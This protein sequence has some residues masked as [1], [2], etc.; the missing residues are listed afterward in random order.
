MSI[1]NG[2]LAKLEHTGDYIALRTYSRAHGCKG[3]FLINPSRFA[4]WLNDDG[5]PGRS[6]YLERDI[7]HFLSATKRKWSIRLKILWRYGS[8][9]CRT[10][11]DEQHFDLPVDMMIRALQ[12]ESIRHLHVEQPN[13]ARLDFTNACGVIKRIRE[14][15]RKRRALTKGLRTSF[16]WRGS[17]IS[18]YDD[19]TPC[20]FYFQERGG[21]CG[22]LILH[23]RETNTP[24]G[25]IYSYEYSVHT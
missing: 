4:R 25:K 18:F 10:V 3:R 15:K 24:V 2:T 7:G 5:D 16:N 19:C 9:G 1:Y 20:G 23:E 12:G 17:F 21:P 11:F 14:D 13:Q 22:G 6:E 8:S